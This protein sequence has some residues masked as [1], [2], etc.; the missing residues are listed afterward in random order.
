MMKSHSLLCPKSPLSYDSWP[1]EEKAKVTLL[2]QAIYPSVL[3][4]TG[5]LCYSH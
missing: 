1:G 5:N 2:L 3:L 4:H